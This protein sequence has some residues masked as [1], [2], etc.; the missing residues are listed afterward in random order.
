MSLSQPDL[1]ID[2]PLL[3]RPSNPPMPERRAIHVSGYDREGRDFYATPSWVTEALLRHVQLR[4][5]IWEPCCGDGAM[6]T[7]LASRGHTVV[8]S[9]IAERGFG[10]A[11]V[12]FMECRTVPGNCRAIVTNPPYGDSGSHGAQ[13][14]SPAAM[15][16][17]LRHALS[18]T[19]SVQGQLALLVRLQ[20]VAGK[21]AADMM[22]AAPFSAMVVLTKRIQWF[23][24]GER[25]NT[26]Q[27]HH[28]W[29]VFDH[30]HP[31]GQPP[32]LLFA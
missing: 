7:V 6:A 21:R 1:L 32:A 30:R 28:A 23:D 16:K 14:K 11:G 9:D 17:F 25:T 19:E 29:V 26:A 12:D 15:L 24:M 3:L 20:W 10:T 13:S 8:A 4:G 27:H 5:P 31:K 18:L 22:S 2:P